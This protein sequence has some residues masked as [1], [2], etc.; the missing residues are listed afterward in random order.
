M[1]T[2]FNGVDSPKKISRKMQV[3]ACKSTLCY[4]SM[5]KLEVDKSKNQLLY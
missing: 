4:Q 5:Y 3:I 2:G 1:T